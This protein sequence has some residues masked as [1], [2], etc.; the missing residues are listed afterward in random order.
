MICLD[1]WDLQ[2]S[3][4]TSSIKLNVVK[5]VK[6]PQYKDL[7]LKADI[8]LFKVQTIIFNDQKLSLLNNLEAKNEIKP[9]CLPDKFEDEQS[10][11]HLLG[12]D[13]IIT[14]WGSTFFYLNRTLIGNQTI[15]NLHILQKATVTIWRQQFC[16]EAY[17]LD[18]TIYDTMICASGYEKDSCKGDSGGPLICPQMI[19]TSD[20]P[21]EEGEVRW[22]LHGIVSWGKLCALPYYPGVYTRITKFV[23]W[24]HETIKQ[25]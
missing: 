17:K 25:N 20:K 7:I 18:N 4:A 3:T 8:A 16:A 10:I 6:H 12:Q 22:I 11:D 21:K 13:C 5:I 23:D 15:Q 14:G 1:I 2:N 19:L 24:I 9:I